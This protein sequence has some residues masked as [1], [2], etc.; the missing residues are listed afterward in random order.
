MNLTLNKL[1]NQIFQFK[2]L[3]LVGLG[4]VFLIIITVVVALTRPQKP[5]E[6]PGVTP[7]PS[8]IGQ[9][10]PPPIKQQP[11]VNGKFDPTAPI[12][13]RSKAAID[14]LRPY[15][16]YRDILTTSTGNKVTFALFTKPL[17]QYT[18]FV[19]MIG[20]DFQSTN[21]DPDLPRNVQDYLCFY[22]KIQCQLR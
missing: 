1:K 6:V 15:L 20:I 22:E 14:K 7:S 3:L 4:I 12:S 21:S 16:I 5:T 13:Q 19:E 8:P 11:V 18:L 17:D 10:I 9:N 2:T